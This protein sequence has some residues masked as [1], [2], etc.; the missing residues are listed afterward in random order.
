MEQQNLETGASKR[1]AA[2]E[3]LSRLVSTLG[4][5]AGVVLIENT[6]NRAHLI[7]SAASLTDLPETTPTSTA[8]DIPALLQ[9][10][11]DYVVDNQTG[12]T[13]IWIC[14]DLRHNDWSAEDGRWTAIREGFSRLDG[15]RFY[16]LSFPH[17]AEDNVAVRVSNVRRRQ[18]GNS[19]ELVLDVGLRRESETEGPLP[20]PLEF[21]IN[22][23][24]S[25]LNVEITQSE[26][27][28]QGH[29]IALDEATSSGWGQVEL[30]ADANRQDNVFYFVFAEPAERRTVIV[31]DALETTEP[32]RVA[33]TSPLDPALAYSATVLTS[34]HVDE[35]DWAGAS[36][37]LWQIP[38]PSG[39]VAQQLENF[40]ESGRP[41]VFFPPTEVSSHHA[42]FGTKWMAWHTAAAERPWGVASW[43]GDSDLLSHTRDGEPLPVGSLQIRRYCAL[44][45]GGSVLAR[46][47]GGPPLL[48]RAG[49]AGRPVY[50][51]ST[52]PDAAHSTLAQNGVVF[53][54]AIQRA[55]SI[56]AAT[57]GNA[58]QLTAG[59]PAARQVAQFVPLSELP[60]AAISSARPFHAGAWRGAEEEILIALN[61]PVEEDQGRPL[62]EEAL[63]KLFSVLNYRNVE[64]R[65]GNST[66][67]A[68]EVW[69]LFLFAMG[70]ALL[71]EAWLCLPEKKQ[72]PAV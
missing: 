27:T 36:L 42:L 30:P 66:A 50:F 32:L 12:R 53:Y 38:L 58:R 26:Y 7:D 49:T 4:G 54:V 67:L 10:A 55:L 65:V 56:G 8:A 24:R 68:S 15:V 1:S 22:G 43:R 40:V 18:I 52:L 59:T 2:L 5:N 11:L 57:Q 45:G 20:I 37:V 61:R 39:I 60:D 70:A 35:V 41:V 62:K 69:R 72:Q 64:D 19:A 17:R 33:V 13:D 16:L 29:T 9:T 47:D 23:A 21:V 48:V 44:D 71:V 46:L 28:L 51:C 34:D 3:K 63:E 25:V 31:S 6:E 14:S